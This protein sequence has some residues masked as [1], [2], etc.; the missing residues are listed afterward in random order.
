VELD[1]TQYS[2]PN[3]VALYRSIQD[4]L[5]ER[6][7]APPAV[8]VKIEASNYER[9][10]AVL[11][12]HDYSGFDWVDENGGADFTARHLNREVRIQL[13]PRVGFWRQYVGKDIMLCA[14]TGDGVYLYP[15]DLMLEKYG[16]RFQHCKSW[17][18][19]GVQYW[20]PGSEPAWVRA[21][22]APYRLERAA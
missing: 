8:G 21:W 19:N 20:P 16:P 14:V 3:L 4:A 2:T 1:L 5:L 17:E 7:I 11:A 12:K 13:K 15:H 9:A 6:G 18:H 10:K 22:L